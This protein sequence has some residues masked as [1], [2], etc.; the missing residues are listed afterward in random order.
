LIRNAWRASVN[1]PAIY[2]LSIKFLR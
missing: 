2:P 1:L